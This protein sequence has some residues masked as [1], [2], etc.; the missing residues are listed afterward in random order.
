MIPPAKYFLGHLPYHKEAPAG[1]TLIKNLS[2][3]FNLTLLIT[4]IKQLNFCVNTFSSLKINQYSNG[5]F[6]SYSR[7]NPIAQNMCQLLP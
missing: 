3:P 6:V 4:L 2:L 5:L 7:K 1:L